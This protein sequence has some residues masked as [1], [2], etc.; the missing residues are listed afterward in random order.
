M[1]K[2]ELLTYILEHYGNVML[3][4]HDEL[5]RLNKRDLEL[6]LADLQKDEAKRICLRN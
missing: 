2:Q 5:M 4:T 1:T 6:Y 3:L